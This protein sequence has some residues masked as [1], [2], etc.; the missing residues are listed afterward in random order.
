MQRNTCIKNCEV[1]Q[2]SIELAKEVKE[3]TELKYNQGLSTLTD[4][5]IA[6]QDLRNAEVNYV[7]NCIAMNQAEIDLLKSQGTLEF[8][9]FR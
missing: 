2:K 6:E 1:Q 3:Q 5:L 7:K 9:D 4:L 8:H